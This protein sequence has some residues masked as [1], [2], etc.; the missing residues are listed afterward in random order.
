MIPMRLVALKLQGS[1]KKKSSGS[2]QSPKK[3]PAKRSGRPQGAR[4]KG[5]ARTWT[6]TTGGHTH[7][8]RKESTSQ[9]DWHKGGKEKG[10][11]KA[12]FGTLCSHGTRTKQMKHEQLQQHNKGK[13]TAHTK[14]THIRTTP[15]RVQNM[16]PPFLF[17]KVLLNPTYFYLFLLIF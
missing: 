17:F 15:Q 7:L 3:R 12:A 14:T 2:L 16:F 9:S 6:T 4:G 1:P 11:R 10:K 8:P 13:A 5:V